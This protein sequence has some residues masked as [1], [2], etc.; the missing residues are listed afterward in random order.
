MTGNRFAL[1]PPMRK[2]EGYCTR[3]PWPQWSACKHHTQLS[4]AFHPSLLSSLCQP[5]SVKL[6]TESAK[7]NLN[8][9][10]DGVFHPVLKEITETED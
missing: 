5:N 8:K 7:G 3:G 9:I 1:E 10:H 6:G 2:V 4:D